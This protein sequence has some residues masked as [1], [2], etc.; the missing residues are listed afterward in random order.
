MLKGLAGTRLVWQYGLRAN[1]TCPSLQADFFACNV[2]A[3]CEW[4]KFKFEVSK[5]EYDC[6]G[7]NDKKCASR[8][9]KLCSARADL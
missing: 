4:K 9:A 5:N 2:N 1:A 3:R 8:Q 7:S 6:R